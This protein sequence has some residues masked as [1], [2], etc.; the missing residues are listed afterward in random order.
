[1]PSG[2]FFSVPVLSGT[3]YIFLARSVRSDLLKTHQY[4]SSNIIFDL[5]NILHISG[6]KEECGLKVFHTDL[7]CHKSLHRPLLGSCI[8][9]PT[10]K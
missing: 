9:L 5:P 8:G 3:H 1:M 6:Q 10:L 4:S 7:V 2:I